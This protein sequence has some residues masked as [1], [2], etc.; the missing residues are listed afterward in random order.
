MRLAAVC[1]DRTPPLSASWASPSKVARSTHRYNFERQSNVRRTVGYHMAW[2][3]TGAWGGVLEGRGLLPAD[4]PSL[5]LALASKTESLSVL[6]KWEVA[7]LWRGRG[8][9][10]EEGEE[11]EGRKADSDAGYVVVT[12]PNVTNTRNRMHYIR[13]DQTTCV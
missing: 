1:R 9:E 8:G 3:S 7:S 5:S 10:G 4:S 12:H 6:T 2:W 13:V 11:G